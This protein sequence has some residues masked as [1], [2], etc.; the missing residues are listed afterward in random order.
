MPD[1]EVASLHAERHVVPFPS[2]SS[3]NMLTVAVRI[4][5]EANRNVIIPLTFTA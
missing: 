3:A 2:L 4:N 5:L 1:I